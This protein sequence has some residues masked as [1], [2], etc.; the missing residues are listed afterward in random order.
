MQSR[1]P[2]LRQRKS[3]IAESYQ[4]L[5]PR[6]LLA[7][8][9]YVDFGFGMTSDLQ[10][11]DQQSASLNGPQVF[12][13]GLSFTPSAIRDA[14][15]VTQ[16]DA[17][18]IIEEIREIFAPFDVTVQQADAPSLQDITATLGST[19]DNDTY[20]LIGIGNDINRA[21]SLE[22]SVVDAGNSDDNLAFVFENAEPDYLTQHFQPTSSTRLEKTYARWIARKAGHAFGL[23]AVE[24][25]YQKTDSGDVYPAAEGDPMTVVGTQENG[26][27]YLSPFEDQDISPSTSYFFTNTD[28][29]LVHFMGESAGVQNSYQLLG[30]NVGFT[31]ERPVINGF[32]LNQLV[33][34]SQSQDQLITVKIDGVLHENIDVSK[35]LSLQL[36]KASVGPELRGDEEFLVDV[37]IDPNV[38][39]DIDID[40]SGAR[41]GSKYIYHGTL[42]Y[43][44]LILEGKPIE[45][46]FGVQFT[47]FG[48]EP[49]G[50]IEFDGVQVSH[51]GGL[52]TGDFD[53]TI[54]VGRF[55]SLKINTGAGDDFV[56]YYGGQLDTGPGYDTV[57]K[58]EVPVF[59]LGK[60]P[61]TQ[62]RTFL[63]EI[64]ID[65]QGGYSSGVVTRF[66]RFIG[67]F[68]S[69]VNS[70]IFASTDAQTNP[71]SRAEW[72]IDG[73]VASLTVVDEDGSSTN[74]PLELVNFVRF[75][76][77][78]EGS[79]NQLEETFT[80][81]VLSSTMVFQDVGKVIVPYELERDPQSISS[82]P[83][84][85][86]FNGE[87]Q[88]VLDHRQASTPEPL[89][90]IQGSR[91]RG[92]FGRVTVLTG[93]PNALLVFR[94]RSSFEEGAAPSL[95]VLGSE[96]FR[97]IL[98]A[99]AATI[100]V[101]WSGNGGSDLVFI[102]STA[103]QSNGDLSKITST[104]EI[105][106]GEGHD[107]LHVNDGGNIEAQDYS[108]SDQAFQVQR[109]SGLKTIIQ[110]ASPVETMQLVGSKGLNHF[111]IKPSASTLFAVD[112]NAKLAQQTDSFMLVEANELPS[113]YLR[114]N[115]LSLGFEQKQSVILSN[116]QPLDLS[117]LYAVA[118]VQDNQT[119]VQVYDQNDEVVT[120]IQ[121]FGDGYLFGAN[122]VMEDLTSD[123]VPE[124]IV[125]PRSHSNPIVRIFDA[126]TG[127]YMHQFRPYGDGHRDGIYLT[128]GNV[129]GDQ[130]PEIIT[131]MM[132]GNPLV[133]VFATNGPV[134][135]YSLVS[136]NRPL[137]SQYQRGATVA[138]ADVN[139]DGFDDVVVGA[140]PGFLPQV[141]IHDM[142][143]ATIEGD[144]SVELNRFLA[145]SH[146]Y[147][148]GV[149]VAAGNVL[150]DSSPDIV[151]GNGLNSSR[152]AGDAGEV[153]IYDSRALPTRN[154]DRALAPTLSL[155]AHPQSRAGV[156]VALRDFDG[157]GQV[158][159]LITASADGSQ[160]VQFFDVADG[161]ATLVDQFFESSD[162]PF[163][164]LNVG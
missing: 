100:D 8:T 137:D 157:D 38:E 145:F 96:S 117:R 82:T 102:G 106:T 45:L 51:V 156:D 134:T 42:K 30:N 124:I 141:A 77:N 88:V 114:E 81:K 40:I 112:A 66:E 63:E 76:G 130:T 146:L 59:Q 2:T 95:E 138:V 68:G 79:G 53:D 94:D 23:Q 5:E 47:Y 150:G 57:H 29:P 87:I 56:Q 153:H 144:G 154:L 104:I 103:K 33:E 54:R 6:Q 39:A 55:G 107:Y 91:S 147:R 18:R 61:V 26:T 118:S 20:I 7:A 58:L 149:N 123:G 21:R 105:D 162:D 161:N 71:G 98:V 70:A 15:G 119:V 22:Y 65:P 24:G 49:I 97:D 32:P 60:D 148:G 160:A 19:S 122:V 41:Y 121:P 83:H 120:R 16:F 64:L 163:S 43:I 127:Q 36:G 111:A 50:P 109:E 62:T 3:R 37:R 101:K 12:G 14:N 113:V 129:E 67:S 17:T 34:I 27:Y 9:V 115:G 25:G 48:G 28:V 11:D 13:S 139:G 10:I 84:E 31:T 93:Q 151:V 99:Q 44:H 131:S 85:V 136:E 116:F 143:D 80:L 1:S 158:D 125:A 69:S 132:N 46:D 92:Q 89:F 90:L 72:L 73:L 86:N 155:E 159:Q 35:G 152:F 74:A 142:K 164:P 128:V 52:T 110:L 75:T 108:L 4:P 133:R 78:H 140:G 135:G 126:L